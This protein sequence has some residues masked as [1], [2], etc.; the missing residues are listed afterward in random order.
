MTKTQLLDKIQSI[1]DII[2]ALDPGLVSDQHLQEAAEKKLESLEQDVRSYNNRT[3]S[4]GS[5]GKD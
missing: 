5:S 3:Q 2:S 1:Q 4:N